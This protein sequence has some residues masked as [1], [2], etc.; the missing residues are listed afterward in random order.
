MGASQ[1]Y[2]QLVA[3]RTRNM[4]LSFGIEAHPTCDVDAPVAARKSVSLHPRGFANSMVLKATL[5]V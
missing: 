5:P 3:C 2:P 1:S 4:Q